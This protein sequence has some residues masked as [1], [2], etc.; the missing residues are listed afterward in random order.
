MAL[1]VEGRYQDLGK[2][3]TP[4]S[5]DLE[6]I[7]SVKH[8]GRLLGPP[9]GA[10]GFA[11]QWHELKQRRLPELERSGV[12][13]REGSGR[14]FVHPDW[15]ERLERF[16]AGKLQQERTLVS[17]THAAGRERERGLER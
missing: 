17:R 12:I 3:K 5:L 1:S 2:G 6:I 7:R 16:R 11:A 15:R 13:Q 4:L 8:E 10:R 14:Y 9:N